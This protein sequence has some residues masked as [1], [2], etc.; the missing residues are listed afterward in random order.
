MLS[1]LR[2]RGVE[3]AVERCELSIVDGPPEGEGGEG[4]S[5]GEEERDTLESILVVRLHCR[6]GS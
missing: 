2:H 4:S 1:I 6:H 5:D 3:S